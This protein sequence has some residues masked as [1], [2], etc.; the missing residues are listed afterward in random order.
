VICRDARVSQLAEADRER[1]VYVA[2][3]RAK[4]R[5]TIL[6]D[7]EHERAFLT[8]NPAIERLFGS[9]PAKKHGK[10]QSVKVREYSP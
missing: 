8:L 9:A 4:E 2:L 5:L 10:H 7:P 3:T 1:E 6:F